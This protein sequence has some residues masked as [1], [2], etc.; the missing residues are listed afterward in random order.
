MTSIVEASVLGGFDAAAAGL[1]EAAGV[2]S[3]SN[4]VPPDRILYA[5]TVRI[6]LSTSGKDG[7]VDSEFSRQA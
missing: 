1:G 3:R 5:D 6:R 4:S 2:E 7:D